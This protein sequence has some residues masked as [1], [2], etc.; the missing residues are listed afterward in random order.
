LE[1]YVTP[2]SLLMGMVSGVLVCLLTIAWSLRRACRANVTA[3]LAGNLESQVRQKS[4]S[5]KNLNLKVGRR[6]SGWSWL[7]ILFLC[8]AIGLSI[9]ATKLAGE[10]QAGSFLGAGF[11]VLT[12][13]LIFVH[14]W[15]RYTVPHPE[16]LSLSGLALGNAKRN[17]LRS[18]LTIGLVAVAS[19]LIAAVSAFRLAP[20]EQGTGGF[21]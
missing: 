7:A 3:L 17:P 21:D 14:R 2:M 8:V 6:I 9:L 13:L 19:F 11:L 4:S 16:K 20:T 10:A 5:L 1:L 12:S 15:L 18:T